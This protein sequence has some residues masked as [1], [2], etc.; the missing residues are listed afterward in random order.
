MADD[1]G[2]SRALPDNVPLARTGGDIFASDPALAEA[3]RREAGE[4]ALPECQTLGELCA[5]AD[6]I[7]LGFTAN[8]HPPDAPRLRPERPAGRHHRIP[9][10]LALPHGHGRRAWPDGPALGRRPGRRPRRPGGQVHPIAQVE[11]GITCPIAMTYSCVPALR[12]EP[13]LAEVW[14]PLVTSAEYDPRP[15]CR[16]RRSRGR[17][18]GWP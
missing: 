9:P 2:P 7:E 17:S 10:E 18:S 12:L 11:A 16:G 15:E 14:E 8:E 13:A 1:T 5:Q 6:T 4:W 3:V